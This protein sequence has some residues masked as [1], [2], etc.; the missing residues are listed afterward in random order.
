MHKRNKTI[1]KQLVKK[2]AGKCRLCGDTSYSVLDVHRILPGSEHGKYTEANTVV[3]CANCHRK[4]H[5]EKTIEIDRWYY[6]T[7][8]YLL[9]IMRDGKEEFL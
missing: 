7:I 5:I 1:D 8:G 3:L 4:V 2:V 6:S 9:R